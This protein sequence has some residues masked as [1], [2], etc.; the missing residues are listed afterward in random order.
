[1]S[2]QSLVQSGRTK[3]FLQS[4]VYNMGW[5]SK[6]AVVKPPIPGA[7]LI[8][9]CTSLPTRIGG[10]RGAGGNDRAAV[11][12][13]PGSRTAACRAARL[14]AGAAARCRAALGA[15]EHF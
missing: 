6:K 9:L 12:R 2:R 10:R 8:Q 14:H 3:T 7:I 5:P 1:A 11:G 13:G 4:N 15:R